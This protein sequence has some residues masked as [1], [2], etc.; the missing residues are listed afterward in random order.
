MVGY[1]GENMSGS[2]DLNDDKKF[3]LADLNHLM[4]MVRE[5]K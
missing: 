1:F 2:L 3:N 4:K 5:N